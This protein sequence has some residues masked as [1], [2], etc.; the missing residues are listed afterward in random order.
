MTLKHGHQG[1]IVPCI[2]LLRESIP[3]VESDVRQVIV[4]MGAALEDDVKDGQ[5]EVRLGRRRGDDFDQE[6]LS[7]FCEH[8]AKLFQFVI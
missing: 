4:R 6:A 1:V 2:E 3:E 8:P 7:K 5:G